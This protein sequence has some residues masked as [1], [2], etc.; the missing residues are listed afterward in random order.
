[1]SG[2]YPTTSR[3]QSYHVRNWRKRYPNLVTLN[4]HFRDNGFRT[5]GVGKVYHSPAGIDADIAVMRPPDLLKLVLNFVGDFDVSNPK[6]WHISPP[7][8]CVRL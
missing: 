5:L 3:E 2:R 7:V 1:M 6:C 8:F 4:Q